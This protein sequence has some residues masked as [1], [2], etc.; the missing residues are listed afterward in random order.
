MSGYQFS[1]LTNG[2]QALLCG[3]SNTQN[4]DV[5]DGIWKLSQD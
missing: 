5:G 2:Q 3:I 1:S 4:A